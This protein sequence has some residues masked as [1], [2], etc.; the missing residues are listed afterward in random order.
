MNIAVISDIHGNSIALK[1]VLDDIKKKNIQKILI[2]GDFLGY[3][4]NHKLV[5]KFLE[6]IDWQGVQGNHD[7]TLFYFLKRDREKIRK[8][9]R[10]FGKS[11]DIAIR[12]LTKKQVA[13]IIDLPKTR[14]VHLHGRKIFMCHGSP[15]NQNFYI[16]PDSTRKVFT[17]IAETDC[18]LLIYGHT[19]YPYIKKIK[20]KLIVNPGSVGQPR[21]KGSLASWAE[22]NLDNMSAKIHRIPF[23]PYKLI[24]QIKKI[25]PYNHY[26]KEVLLR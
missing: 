4:F 16:Y 10:E 21:D 8:Y 14:T 19:H 1:E 26:L 11:I 13:S 25:N 20:G 3:Y 22:V 9:R 15:W 12:D 7:A 18:D 6:N 23:E 24:K 5:F 2:C 17:R